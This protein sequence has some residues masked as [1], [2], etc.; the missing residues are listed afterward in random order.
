MSDFIDAHVHVWTDDFRRFHLAENFKPDDIRPRSFTPD[1]LF[2][3]T[4][5]AG[6]ARV[7]LIQISFYGFDN[8][9]MLEAIER[10]KDVFVG[11]ALIDPL[12]KDPDAQMLDLAKRGVRAFRIR[13]GAKLPVARWLEP[14]GYAKM[15]AAGAKHNLGMSCLVNP[16]GLPEL[17]RMCKAYPDTPVIV[18]HLCLLG[19]TGTIVERDVDALCALAKYPRVLIKVGAFYALGARKSPYLDL[20][21]MI[22][23]VVKAFGARRCMWE[24]DS[25]Y[26]I[27]NAP[28]RDSL[29]L[30]RTQLKFLTDE[31]RTW[32]LRRTAEEFFFRAK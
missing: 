30:V 26:Q 10:H 3:H 16:A 6:V 15:F 18:D 19:G 1:E 31:E 29:D 11:T 4:K 9:Y 7:N 14:E 24:S 27:N 8:R 25:P 28:Y 5:E 32:L 13:P 21:P 20:A 12:Q 22:E 23:K 17:E 2:R